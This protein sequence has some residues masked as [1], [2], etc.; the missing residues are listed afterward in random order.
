MHIFIFIIM[1][2]PEFSGVKL[3]IVNIGATQ[4]R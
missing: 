4:I 1:E 3:L 2:F